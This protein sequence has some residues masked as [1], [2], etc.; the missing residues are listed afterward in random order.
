MGDH[1]SYDIGYVASNPIRE[2]TRIGHERLS[3]LVKKKRFYQKKRWIIPGSTLA[4]FLLVFVISLF[5]PVLTAYIMKPLINGTRY[6][7]PGN[8]ETIKS[9]INVEKDIVYDRQLANSLL[10][11]YYPKNVN[12]PLPVIMWIHG[13]GFVGNSKESTQDYGMA[14]ASEGYVVA[15]INYALA[16]KYKY[17]TPVIQANAALQYLMEHAAQ[18]HGDMSRIFVGGDSAGAQIAGQIAAVLTDEDLART[19]NI[20]PSVNKNQLKGALLYCG[21]YNMDTVRSTHHPFIGTFLW[22]YT[23]VK[24]FEAYAKIDELSTV[25]HITPDYPPAFVTVGNKDKLEPQTLE[26]VDVLNKKTVEVESVL[27]DGPDYNLDHEYQFQMDTLPAQQTFMKA[28]Q[29][30]NKRSK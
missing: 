13:G 23:G 29:F 6:K 22:A 27:Y 10:D 7:P 26:L 5:T 17:P 8:L 28:V 1:E 21:A 14:L 20:V 11:I 3:E 4:A 19:M 15:N 2:I 12:H 24:Q 9:H 16:P 18:Y 25:K 30:L